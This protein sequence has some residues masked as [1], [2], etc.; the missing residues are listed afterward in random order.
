MTPSKGE[1]EG[2]VPVSAMSYTAASKELDEIVEFFEGRDVDV[3]Q[4]VARLDR[5]TAIV[6]E[7]DR[8]LRSTRTQVEALVPRLEAILEREE[9]EME[10]ADF[11][12]SPP[13]GDDEEPSGLF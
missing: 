4:L 11:D 1:A 6:D 10:I 8:R 13:P 5:A 3:D 9:P 2:P 7:L 12:D